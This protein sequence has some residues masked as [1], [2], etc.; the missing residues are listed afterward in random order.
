MKNNEEN[1][2]EILSWIN[3]QWSYQSELWDGVTFGIHSYD[4]EDVS[5]GRTVIQKC[6][7]FYVAKLD[8]QVAQ[9]KLQVKLLG[10]NG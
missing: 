6:R 9:Y 10:I 4:C 2:K 1:K 3:R 8:L 5:P 7:K